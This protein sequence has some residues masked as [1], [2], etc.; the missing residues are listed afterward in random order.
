MISVLTLFF[1]KLARGK[2]CDGKFFVPSCCFPLENWLK[3]YDLRFHFLGFRKK[4]IRLKFSAKNF[5][6]SC[7]PPDNIV[8]YS[9]S[10]SFFRKNGS[11]FD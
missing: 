7:F 11:V 5:T 1:E 8:K 6:T 2:Q 3:F 4:Q 10:Q 9:D